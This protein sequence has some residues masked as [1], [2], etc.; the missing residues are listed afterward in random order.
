MNANSYPT[1]QISANNNSIYGRIPLQYDPNATYAQIKGPTRSSSQDQLV[2]MTNP[3]AQHQYRRPLYQHSLSNQMTASYPPPPSSLSYAQSIQSLPQHYVQYPNGPNVQSMQRAVRPLPM[4][5]QWNGPSN[6]V[7]PQPQ[8]L[9]Q[10]M[11]D[12]HKE[13]SPTTSTSSG[14]SL[15]NSYSQSS[16]VNASPN[17]SPPNSYNKG[18]YNY[19]QQSQPMMASPNSPA[20]NMPINFRKVRTRYACVGENDSELSFEPNMIITNGM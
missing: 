15:L 14:D 20:Q 5:N 18:Y 2:G 8:H 16:Q 3:M 12:N 11:I 10:Q 13:K 17:T 19:R 6:V 7:H 4:Y 9:H 1:T